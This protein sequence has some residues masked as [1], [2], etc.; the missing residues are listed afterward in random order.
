MVI[1]QGTH[2]AGRLVIF[3]LSEENLTRLRAGQPIKMTRQSHGR[4]IPEGV[5]IV[6]DYAPTEKAF[7]ESLRAVGVQVQKGA[8]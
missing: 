4:T 6:I 1:A 7:V 3:A 2:D 8:V 5:T